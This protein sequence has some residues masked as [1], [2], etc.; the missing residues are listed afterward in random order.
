VEIESLPTVGTSVRKRGVHAQTTH[1]A[2]DTYSRLRTPVFSFFQ[3]SLVLPKE[4]A[5]AES[6]P[7]CSDSL[8]DRT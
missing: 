3:D 1:N 7:L 5:P 6:H 2:K 8:A 4:D